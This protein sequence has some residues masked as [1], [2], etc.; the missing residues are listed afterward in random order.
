MLGA[1]AN[2]GFFSK[3]ST[4]PTPAPPRP[5]DRPGQRRHH[6]KRHSLHVFLLFVTTH[7]STQENLRDMLNEIFICTDCRRRRMD[8]RTRAIRT[9]TP[10]TKY[11]SDHSYPP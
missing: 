1:I 4:A 8:Y 3:S 5:T 2:S 6:H 9:G 11:T 7:R 10:P